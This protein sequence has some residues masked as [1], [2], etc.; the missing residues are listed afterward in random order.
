MVRLVEREKK[1]NEAGYSRNNNPNKP[2]IFVNMNNNKTTTITTIKIPTHPYTPDPP[3]PPSL[4]NPFHPSPPSPPPPPLSFTTFHHSRIVENDIREPN[5]SIRDP[6]TRGAIVVIRIPS[7][8]QIIPLH[9]HLRVDNHLLEFGILCEGV[10]KED[11]LS[12]SLS[13]C[14]VILIGVMVIIKRK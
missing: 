6:D 14:G 7:Q 13:E 8:E 10:R 3:L 9:N 5:I 12:P 2:N 4:L 1:R 11:R